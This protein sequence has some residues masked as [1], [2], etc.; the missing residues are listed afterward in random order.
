MNAK[1]VLF[2]AMAKSIPWIH[3]LNGMPVNPEGI[4]AFGSDGSA[5][6]FVDRT[7]YSKIPEKPTKNMSKKK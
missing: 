7:A 5:V 1:N 6:K 3:S 4:I 2:H